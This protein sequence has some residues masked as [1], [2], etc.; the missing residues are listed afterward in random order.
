MLLLDQWNSAQHFHT[1]LI[2]PSYSLSPGASLSCPVSF[3]ATKTEIKL[4]PFQ[5]LNMTVLWVVA[6]CYLIDV[7]R[8]LKGSCCLHHQGDHL[9]IA[10]MMEAAST[11]EKSVNFYQT[12]RCNNPEDSHLRTRC[13]RENLKSHILTFIANFCKSF[14]CCSFVWR[15]DIPSYKKSIQ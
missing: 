10:L 7:Y 9:L 6:P 14:Y 8:R 5:L 11:S 2:P 12:T 15:N 1:V 4:N 3:V 13:Y